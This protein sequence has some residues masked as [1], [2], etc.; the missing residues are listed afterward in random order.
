MKNTVPPIGAEIRFHLEDLTLSRDQRTY[1]C[2]IKYDQALH[3]WLISPERGLLVFLNDKPEPQDNYL[4]ITKI[5][6]T[7]QGVYADPVA[8]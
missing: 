8:R 6:P 2:R 1:V 7:G 4:R 5:Q 3:C